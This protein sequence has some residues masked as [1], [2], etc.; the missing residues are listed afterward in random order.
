M[1]RLYTCTWASAQTVQQDFFEL[2]APTNKSVVLHAIELEQTTE[3]GDAQEEGL[4]ILLKRGVGS[5]T[6][7]SGGTTPTPVP[8]DAGDSAFGGTTKINNTTKMVAGSGVIS[9]LA[10]WAWNVRVPFLKLFTPELRP[11]IKGGD[12]FTVE[13][14]T[15]PADSIT[16]SATIWFEEIG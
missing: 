4:A 16:F 7:G 3:V 10:N 15:N 14:G 13:L 11:V 2:I 12:R 9:T 6:T 1:A 8:V 5:V